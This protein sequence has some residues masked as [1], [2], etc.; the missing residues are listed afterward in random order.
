MTVLDFIV[1]ALP[2]SGTTWAANW[3]TTDQVH[4]VHDPLYTV[5]YSDWDEQ[6]PARAPGRPV[7]VSCT[8]A[9]RWADWLNAHPTRKLILHRDVGEVIE[10]MKAI[11]LPPVSPGD[12]AALDR[13]I[14]LHLPFE[15]LFDP[16]GARAAWEYLVPSVP[17]NEA[18]HREL[19]D[20]EMQPK[21]SGLT[22]DPKVTRRLMSEL[23][24]IAGGW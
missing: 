10:S 14:G 16:I 24:R 9:W 1:V 4:C 7:G 6:L 13:V 20:I 2:R 22:I 8:G 3:L 5:H 23:E 11:G 21:F 15:D 19:V 12:A 18:R 17:F